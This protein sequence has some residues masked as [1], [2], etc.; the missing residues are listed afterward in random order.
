MDCWRLVDGLWARS[1]IAKS[2]SKHDPVLRAADC[3]PTANAVKRAAASAQQQA[4]NQQ[5]EASTTHIKK[6]NAIRKSIKHHR[7][8][9]LETYNCEY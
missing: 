1:L 2:N 7:S 5:R 6:A 8:A 9:C 3:A 4:R